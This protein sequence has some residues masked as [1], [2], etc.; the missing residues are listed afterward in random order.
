MQ[1]L[2]HEI[3]SHILNLTGPYISVASRVC[4]VWRALT[5]ETKRSLSPHCINTK[6][7]LKYVKSQGFH[8][9]PVLKLALKLGRTGIYK[10]FTPPEEIFSQEDFGIFYHGTHLTQLA[11]L[12][13]II[14]HVKSWE[15]NSFL[16]LSGAADSGNLLALK[17]LT[18][19]VGPAVRKEDDEDLIH[20]LVNAVS[21]GHLE[22]L[23]YIVSLGWPE[24]YLSIGLGATDFSIPCLE[25]LMSTPHFQLDTGFLEA[26]ASGG[27]LV[28]LKWLVEQKAPA[29]DVLMKYVVMN[30]TQVVEI[31]EILLPHY[32]WRT[33][34]NGYIAYSLDLDTLEWLDSRQEVT[35]SSEVFVGAANRK[36][37]D[38]EV[39][40]FFLQRGV[41]F[42]SVVFDVVATLGKL[43]LFKYLESKGL[44]CNKQHALQTAVVNVK[45]EVA[46]YLL[47]KGCQ[48]SPLLHVM[49]SGLLEQGY[50][51]EEKAQRVRR[52][53]A[54]HGLPP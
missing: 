49:I 18:E 32:T 19:K 23:K 17:Y 51:T 11:A 13:W 10:R 54:E 22:C 40:D 41:S 29:S 16:L 8:L 14:S 36:E 33:R 53:L 15:N 34:S 31:L 44:P 39:I 12:E 4:T 42:N 2:P 9:L 20:P 35:W 3:T 21:G 47:Q 37:G 26:A 27:E 6:S 48:L 43:E 52:W 28:L 5:P 1:Y 24:E 7:L 46:E 25:W 45:L 50:M 30:R 38:R